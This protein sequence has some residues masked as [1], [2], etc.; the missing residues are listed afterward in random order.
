MNRKKRS[1]IMNTP[2]HDIRILCETLD[3]VSIATGLRNDVN[4][5]LDRVFK[6]LRLCEEF[7]RKS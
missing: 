3:D 2:I 4:K 6:W 5:S 1:A 7:E